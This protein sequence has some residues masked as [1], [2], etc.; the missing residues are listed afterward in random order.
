MLYVDSVQLDFFKLYSVYFSNQPNATATFHAL[1]AN[2]PAFQAF[3]Q[4]PVSPSSA[5]SLSVSL[6]IPLSILRKLLNTLAA[7]D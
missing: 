7:E 2:N 1:E 3:L 6:F 5:T 4:V